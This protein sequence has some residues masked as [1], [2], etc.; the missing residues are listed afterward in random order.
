LEEEKRRKS[1]RKMEEE[2]QEISNLSVGVGS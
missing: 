2:F 1:N